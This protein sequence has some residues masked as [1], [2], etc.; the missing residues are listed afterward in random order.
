[1]IF[2]LVVVGLLP[3]VDAEVHGCVQVHVHVH[4]HVDA[5]AAA[6]AL[7]PLLRIVE[8]GPEVGVDVH[9][10]DAA[11]AAAAA[12]RDAG[13]A[14]GVVLCNDLGAQGVADLVGGTHELVHVV[15]A[16]YAAHHPVHD[17]VHVHVPAL[18]VHEPAAFAFAPDSLV[19]PQLMVLVRDLA[20]R[21]GLFAAAAAVAAV[22]AGL[23]FHAGL[24]VL[25]SPV[26]HNPCVLALAELGVEL[27][28]VVG[29]VVLLGPVRGVPRAGVPCL[30]WEWAQ[31]GELPYLPHEL[32]QEQEQL[33][34]AWS[35]YL[36][37]QP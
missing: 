31:V 17:P 10:K 19:H 8:V 15:D 9:D 33:G 12:D 20:A 30:A 16:Y 3:R 25:G 37:L 11:A 27:N 32:D 14:V 34:Q 1:M 23:D 4:V 2:R 21:V 26:H 22:H 36:Y 35:A 18:L 5:R 29:H 7:A 28:E 13:V 24:I 6:A